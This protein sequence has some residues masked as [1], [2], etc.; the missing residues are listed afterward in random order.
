[1]YHKLFEYSAGD[2]CFFCYYYIDNYNKYAMSWSYKYILLKLLIAKY[3]SEMLL[4]YSNISL[5]PPYTAI[6]TR[7][8]MYT[9]RHNELS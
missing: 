2:I 8:A 1:M 6:M 3:L 7:K 4:T 9:M 5:I